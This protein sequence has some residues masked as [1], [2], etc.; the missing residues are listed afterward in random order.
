M[1]DLQSKLTSTHFE[2]G[3]INFAAW[4][5]LAIVFLIFLLILTM[6]SVRRHFL[7]WTVK[8][9]GFGI[10]LGFVLA[11]I[12]EGFLLIGGRTALTEVLGWKNAP[13][14]I[15]VAIDKGRARLVD[16]LG[17][18]DEIPSSNAA[19]NSSVDQVVQGYQSLSPD[20]AKSV[21][22]FVCTP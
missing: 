12:I 15:Q 14:P 21:K 2:A 6:A 17:A 22:K 20:D 9:A 7:E 11:L 19:E 8:G 18:T 1:Q 16:V 5:I 3:G 10:V 4:Q 13:K